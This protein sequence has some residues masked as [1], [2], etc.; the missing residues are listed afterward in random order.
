MPAVLVLVQLAHRRGGTRLM[1][2]CVCGHDR[3]EHH[4]MWGC[5][6]DTGS[7]TGYPRPCMCATYE[8]DEVP[9]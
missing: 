9:F 1:E 6:A 5:V 3:E 7:A 8:P 2:V 4:D